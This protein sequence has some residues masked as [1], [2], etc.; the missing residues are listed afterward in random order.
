ME[1]RTRRLASTMVAATGYGGFDGQR[2]RRGVVRRKE[3]GMG[4]NRLAGKSMALREQGAL[5]AHPERVTDPLFQPGGFFDP[6]DL[7]QVKYEM[8][9]RTGEDGLT[10]TGAAAAFGFSR[11]AFYKAR[12]DFEARGLPGLAPR[13][14]GPRGAH[15]L[16]TEVLAFLAKLRDAEPAISASALA[17]RVRERFGRRVHPRSIE[18][19]LSRSKKK[20]RRRRRP[21]MVRPEP[22]GER[23]AVR[24]VARPRRR[25]QSRRP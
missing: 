8:L 13:K 18:R 15:K 3:V 6:A 25:R 14:R 17:G 11:P 10:V 9:R 1:G 2:V 4:Q 5:N 7:V 23:R 21:G 22:G 16:T 19:A 20:P 12:S 24:K